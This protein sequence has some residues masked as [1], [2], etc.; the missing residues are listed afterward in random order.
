[1]HDAWLARFD[2]DNGIRGE[3]TEV[4][5]PEAEGTS[6]GG[7]CGGAQRLVSVLRTC[8]WHSR[9]PGT[10]SWTESNSR[11]HRQAPTMASIRRA[12]ED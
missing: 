3:L 5:Q 2:G 7:G 8:S 6:R 4:D 10:W 9:S 11:R 12:P 1:M